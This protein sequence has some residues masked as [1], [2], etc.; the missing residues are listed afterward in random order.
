MAIRQLREKTILKGVIE[1]LS[2]QTVPTLAKVLALF[3]TDWTFISLGSIVFPRVKKPF[4][5]FHT[6]PDGILVGSH[7][8][9]RLI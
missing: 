4:P 6:F 8:A 1:F 9:V 5:I 2:K 3:F 7:G